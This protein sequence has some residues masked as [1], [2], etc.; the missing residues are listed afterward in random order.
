MEL[1][2]KKKVATIFAFISAICLTLGFTLSDKIMVSAEEGTIIAGQDAPVEETRDIYMEVGAYIRDGES[3]S[4]EKDPQ[5][6]MFETRVKK[7]Y[8][9]GLSGKTVTTGT[10]F[11]RSTDLEN[12]NVSISADIFTKENKE[13]LK[14]KGIP[15]G[16]IVNKNNGFIKSE[17]GDYLSYNATITHIALEK[18]DVVYY[19]RGYICI[20]GEYTYT[21]FTAS[22]NGRSVKQVAMNAFEYGEPSEKNKKF[23]AE[24][25]KN[26]V[27][28]DGVQKY[29]Y[30]HYTNGGETGAFKSAS[31]LS[32]I[33]G[34]YTGNAVEFTYS[35]AVN[36]VKL[37]AN[38]FSDATGKLLTM[39]FALKSNARDT[40]MSG[41][42]YF[43]TDRGVY[44]KNTVKYTTGGNVFVNYH[45][46]TDY[47]Q[48]CWYQIAID[49]D[50]SVS[51]DNVL[52][53]FTFASSD[54]NGE[55]YS[56]LIG[57]IELIDKTTIEDAN[58]YL[59]IANQFTALTSIGNNYGT[60]TY[61]N[62]EEVKA[63]NYTGYEGNATKITRTNVVVATLTITRANYDAYIAMN[64]LIKVNYA[65]GANTNFQT[66]TACQNA[67]LNADI[68]GTT[69]LSIA[70]GTWHSKEI[71]ASTLSSYATLTETTATI[72][73]VGFVGTIYIGNIE[74]VDKPVVSTDYFLQINEN[75]NNV[76]VNYGTK[77]YTSANDL[78]ELNISGD[79]TG[80]A[81]KIERENGFHITLSMTKADYEQYCAITGG[82]LRIW[83]AATGSA[84]FKK[85]SDFN[86]IMNVGL[87]AAETIE[88]NTWH[89]KEISLSELS[90][91]ATVDAETVAIKLA[92]VAGTFYL[93][94]IE[95]VTE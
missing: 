68:Q 83:F 38:A 47:K 55:D 69:A 15:L 10:I 40:I 84:K 9:E 56:I 35:N 75:T 13:T 57:D 49:A 11:L 26:T 86:A 22:E 41:F 2:N 80:N 31:D 81:I 3:I 90:T 66:A 62:A 63:L 67:I 54:F 82:K 70:T 46:Q 74:I 53:L 91:Y 32:G 16:E 94:D 17:E 95:I 45:E 30:V 77:T 8:W 34:G 78:T 1:K 79:Y 14:E 58:N 87:E 28:V 72:K 59:F 36:S 20:D 4:S 7:T 42:P 71:D 5:G 50:I 18:I 12:A 19:A 43:F 65:V 24:Y 25:T 64:K 37:P 6:L 48:N 73:L 76:S 44:D 52:D 39:W 33:A 93:G 60:K 88:V 21:D 92:G 89:Y 27:V 85:Y 51:E 23:F 29:N 61:A